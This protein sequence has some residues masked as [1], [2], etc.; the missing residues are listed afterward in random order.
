MD[1]QTLIQ[2]FLASPVFAVV[3]ASTNREKY[4]NKVLRSYLQRGRTVHCVHPS[5]TAIEGVPCVRSIR[6]LPEG[7]EAL[8][9]ITPPP[10]TERIVREAAEKGIRR[11]WMQP[12]AES[13][14]ALKLCEE[15][16]LSVIAGGP[17]VLVLLGFRETR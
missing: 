8:S 6:D 2:E 3:G 12:G 13:P 15:L 5:E 16:G 4:G 7:V 10:I 9:I 17:C 14:A 11:L 1:T